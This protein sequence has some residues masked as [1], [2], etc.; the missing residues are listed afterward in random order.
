MTQPTPPQPDFCKLFLVK[1]EPIEI[2]HIS[3]P[4]S[5][6]R[7]YPQA[8]K[9]SLTQTHHL[10]GGISETGIDHFLDVF[11]TARPHLLAY[12]SPY[13]AANQN[14]VT[15]IDTSSLPV[16]LS[17]L[18]FLLKFAIPQVDITP[19]NTAGELLPPGTDQFTVFTAARILFL[20]GMP[21]NPTRGGDTNK[22]GHLIELE[23]KL[24]A[25]CEPR[26]VDATPGTG[27]IGIDLVELEITGV[28]P[29]GLE[30]ILECILTAVLRWA[31]AQ[32]IL[33]FHVFT[34]DGVSLTLQQGPLAVDNQIEVRGDIS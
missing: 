13:F 10:F 25:L 8:L 22:G 2:N 7:V 5:S 31:L 19:P 17:G 14:L 6:E 34:L 4:V 11:F 21:S 27:T 12:G 32:V 18:Q 20:C 24:A 30:Q 33:P 28:A 26:V 15:L 9:M 1:T 3:R 16:F 29:P 23:L